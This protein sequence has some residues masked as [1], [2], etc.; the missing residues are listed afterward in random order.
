MLAKTNIT[1]KMKISE[2]KKE[3]KARLAETFSIAIGINLIYT[4]VFWL[5]TYLGDK[6]TGI[7]ETIL[8]AAITIISI[9]LNYGVFEAMLKLFR[10]EKVELFDFATI[11]FTNFKKIFSLYIAMVIRLLIPMILIFVLVSIPQY[12]LT[13]KISL[14]NISLI[15]KAISLVSWV[16]LIYFLYKTFSFVLG[17][18]ILMDNPDA[19]SQEILDASAKLMKGNKFN[20]VKLLI[21]FFGWLLLAA[22][23]ITL[24]GIVNVYLGTIVSFA[25]IITLSTYISFTI[26]AFYEELIGT[27]TQNAN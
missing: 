8:A 9:P 14:D 24:A 1:K 19:Q 5:M 11:G 16:C 6:T 23:V 22:L 25:A 27:V 13:W 4:L 3:A 26:I 15:V 2:L 21:S 10:G 20:L 12:M 17:I 18:F 7:L